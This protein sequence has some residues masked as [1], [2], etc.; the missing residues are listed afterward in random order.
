MQ[1]RARQ[2]LKG[3]DEPD[4]IQGL[5]HDLCGVDL[6]SKRHR[7]AVLRRAGIPQAE[8]VMV[9]K[10]ASISPRSLKMLGSWQDI[11]VKPVQGGIAGF[12]P[13]GGGGLLRITE[14]QGGDFQSDLLIEAGSARVI[15][16]LHAHQAVLQ[17]KQLAE[18]SIQCGITKENLLAFFHTHYPS[19]I[20]AFEKALQMP[21]PS[22]RSFSGVKTWEVRLIIRVASYLSGDPFFSGAYAKV[23]PH[24]FANIGQG[25]HACDAKFLFA[26][27]MRRDLEKYPHAY[28]SLFIPRDDVLAESATL[29]EVGTKV[30][31]AWTNERWSYAEKLASF[32]GRNRVRAIGKKCFAPLAMSVDLVADKLT[33]PD[34]KPEFPA[35]SDSSWKVMEASTQF[36]FDGL[37]LTH[38]ASAKAHEDEVTNR[39][40]ELHK[41]LRRALRF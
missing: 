37:A 38:Y 19:E 6:T 30:W 33:F 39:R 34:D 28:A 32:L 18:T 15:Q 8:R 16:W 31:K 36:G 12:S 27:I 7:M 1:Q 10:G 25:A 4:P 24:S 22:S 14:K 2:S 17:G 5:I 26:D 29:F 35:F 20:F 9:K 3:L 13:D 23:S 40:R 41:H 21:L 11:F